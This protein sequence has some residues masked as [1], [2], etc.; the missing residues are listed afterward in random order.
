MSPGLSQLSWPLVRPFC[1]AAI[2]AQWA[3]L[4]WP[5]ACRQKRGVDATAAGPWPPSPHIDAFVQAVGLKAA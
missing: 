5:M 4:L 2:L 1:R 3:G